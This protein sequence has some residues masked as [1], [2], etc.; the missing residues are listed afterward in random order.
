L[1][2][3]TIPFGVGVAISLPN[4][5]FIETPD[6]PTTVD[7]EREVNREEAPQGQEGESQELSDE[8]SFDL[9]SCKESALYVGRL[10]DFLDDLKRAVKEYHIRESSKVTTESSNNKIYVVK[11]DAS[12][13]GWRFYAAR[14]K[15][16]DYF[17]IKT[18]KGKHVCSKEG[19]IKDHRNMLCEFISKLILDLIRKK[20]DASPKEIQAFVHERYPCIP[21]YIKAWKAKELARAHLFGEWKESYTK[22]SPFLNAIHVTNPGTKVEWWSDCTA[23]LNVRLLKGVAWA[24]APAIEGF[25]HCRLVISVDSMILC[26]KYGGRMLLAVAYDANGQVL[27]LS[28]VVIKVEDD[29]SWIWFMRWF[30]AEVVGSHLLCVI[31]DRQDS[32]LRLF[33]QPNSDR[34]TGTGQ[35]FH[36]YCTRYLCESIRSTFKKDNLVKLFRWVSRQPVKQISSGDDANHGNQ[37]GG[38]Q[39]FSQTRHVI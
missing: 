1:F 25:K 24:F 26:S 11:C 8:E 37:L 22:L 39:L 14:Y 34:C 38:I 35:A 7:S 6:Y 33:D 10:F 31:S 23:D 3:S 15:D 19:D 30:R 2:Y 17:Q 29:E 21:S 4:V 28:F 20:G 16:G 18:I 13:C 32:I 5:E 9:K 12:M 36:R 27:P